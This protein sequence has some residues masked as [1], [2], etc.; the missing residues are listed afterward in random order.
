MPNYHKHNSRQQGFTLV[1]IA[2]VITIIAI[3]IG[4]L[5]GTSHIIR[6][7]RLNKTVEQAEVISQRVQ[8]FRDMYKAY[9]GDFDRAQQTW[10]AASNCSA[11]ATAKETCNGNGNGIVELNGEQY[12]V[13]QHLSNASL[14]EGKWFGVAGSPAYAAGKS[15]PRGELSRSVYVMHGSGEVYNR[16]GHRV[17]F[18][19]EGAN[20]GD[21]VISPADLAV[22]DSKFD[23]GIA[24]T[25]RINALD[26]S[27]GSGSCLSSGAYVKSN[28][29]EACMM[30]YWLQ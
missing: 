18:T 24:G 10:G 19:R 16:S 3:L 23:D 9:P 12:R 5:L 22:L 26:G 29:N 8:T 25:G 4:G 13:W 21:A 28:A 30:V 11:I 1:E 2:M 7:I 14:Y 20:V 27:G 17:Y 6:K 15:V